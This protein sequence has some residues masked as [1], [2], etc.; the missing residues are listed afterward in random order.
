MRGDPA[1]AVK[2]DAT[3]R[4]DHADVRTVDE[5]RAPG[6][7]VMLMSI[8]SF[9]AT[10]ARLYRL[11]KLGEPP[12]RDGNAAMIVEREIIVPVEK[13]QTQGCCAGISVASRN[14]KQW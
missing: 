13:Q 12:R 7:E 2:P 1:L 4:H 3:I 6:V 5:H 11:V 9:N 10:V 14:S 8:S